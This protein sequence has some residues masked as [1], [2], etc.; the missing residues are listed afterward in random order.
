MTVM[1]RVNLVFKDENSYATMEYWNMINILIAIFMQSMC[2]DCI[3]KFIVR[4]NAIH[5]SNKCILSNYS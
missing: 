5:L 2:L 4:T 3:L 1:K